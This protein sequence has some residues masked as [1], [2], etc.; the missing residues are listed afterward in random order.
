[1]ILKDKYMLSYFIMKYKFSRD[2]DNG[3]YKYDTEKDQNTSEG[4]S[5]CWLPK[6]KSRL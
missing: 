1:M 3:V 2:I 6:E 4:L 5:I